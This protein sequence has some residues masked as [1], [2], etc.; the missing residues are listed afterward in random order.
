[1]TSTLTRPLRG[2][3]SSAPHPAKLHNAPDQRLPLAPPSSTAIPRVTVPDTCPYL[4]DHHRRR[5]GSWKIGAV[6]SPRGASVVALAAGFGELRPHPIHRGASTV[7]TLV[8]GPIACLSY[9]LIISPQL[10]ATGC[11]SPRPRSAPEQATAHR[12]RYLPHCHRGRGVSS[13]VVVQSAPFMSVVVTGGGARRATTARRRDQCLTSSAAL[14]SSRHGG[15]RSA[16]P[17][18]FGMIGANAFYSGP[19]LKGSSL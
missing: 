6:L 7:N 2:L 16:A 5:I 1:M 15:W 10:E 17:D 4:T 3:V 14:V 11:K 9:N 8:H 19:T 18:M 13:G 12:D